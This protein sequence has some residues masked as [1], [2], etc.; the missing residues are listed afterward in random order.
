MPF[1]LKKG[2]DPELVT[3]NDQSFMTFF[4]MSLAGSIT[5][6]VAVMAIYFASSEGANSTFFLSGFITTLAS[7]AIY[8]MWVAAIGR[9]AA[10]TNIMKTE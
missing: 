10:K 1:L 7:F 6:V 5:L 3:I 9:S 4:L 8:M 2:T